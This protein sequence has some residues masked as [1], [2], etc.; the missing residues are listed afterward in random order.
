MTSPVRDQTRADLEREWRYFEA[1]CDSLGRPPLPATPAAVADYLSE[2]AGPAGTP[3]RPVSSLWRVRRAIDV[4]HVAAGFAA[5][6]GDGHVREAWWAIL[7]AR[8]ARSRRGGDIVL[9]DVLDPRVRAMVVMLPET[10]VGWRNRALLLVGAG[11]ALGPAEVAALTADDVVY[12]E[13]EATVWLPEGDYARLTARDP[14]LSP[15]RALAHWRAAAGAEDGP[16]FRGV[17]RGGN[18]GTRALTDAAV[19]YVVRR[20]ARAAGLADAD[21]LTGAVLRS[22]LTRGG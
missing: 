11:A 13:A 18:V 22:R 4:F 12:N 19:L 16:L 8:G 15:G 21:R 2:I 20:A 7:D 5:P 14:A 10:M 17:D 9:D 3:G 6:S 1:W